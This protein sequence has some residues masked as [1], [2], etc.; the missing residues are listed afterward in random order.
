MTVI[1][2]YC[3]MKKREMLESNRK[4][5]YKRRRLPQTRLT[6]CSY[7]LLFEVL[8][9]ILTN[10]NNLEHIDELLLTGD[11]DHTAFLRETTSFPP[12]CEYPVRTVSSA[13]VATDH[14]HHHHH[15]HQHMLMTSDAEETILA[16]ELLNNSVECFYREPDLLP[17]PEMICSPNHYWISPG[18][19]QM[20]ERVQTAGRIPE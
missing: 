19:I 2:A 5:R 4:P 3:L 8:P 12:V 10:M 15:H 1:T 17:E 6:R 7:E 11:F 9:N 13:A 20:E 18:G 14:H 16:T